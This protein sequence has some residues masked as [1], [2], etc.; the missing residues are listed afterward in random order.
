[1]FALWSSVAF[2]VQYQGTPALTFRVDRP[3]GDYV[4][5]EVTVQKLRVH[6]CGGGTTDV[7]VGATV[8]PV[9]ANTVPIP[10]GD[11]CAVT[12]YWSTTLDIDGPTY[13]VR[14]SQ[15]TTTVALDTEIDPKALTPY[16]VIAGTMSGG[17]P[18]LLVAID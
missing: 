1:L 15:S 11:H 2:A 6:H 4:E 7:T 13:T 10:A 18:W 16:S 14:Y 5:G 9:V 3:A 17:G 12:F 8:D